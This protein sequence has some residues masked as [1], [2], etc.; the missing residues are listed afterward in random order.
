[1]AQVLLGDA[2]N[3][4]GDTAAARTAWQHALTLDPH[5]RQARERLS[6]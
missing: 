1:M 2:L 5:N 6:Q 4:T 3:A